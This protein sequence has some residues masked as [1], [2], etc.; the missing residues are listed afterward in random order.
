MNEHTEQE[1]R[2]A[3]SDILEAKRK[4]YKLRNLV[5]DKSNPLGRDFSMAISSLEEAESRLG[6]F[7]LS[8][9]KVL[10]G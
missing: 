3:I 1:I 7:A 5:T 8:Y 9:F 10:E 6:Y 2:D 4:L